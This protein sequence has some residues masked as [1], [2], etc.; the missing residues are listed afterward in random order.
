MEWEKRSMILL[1]NG[2]AQFSLK[3]SYRM[4][5][6]GCSR[7]MTYSHLRHEL[8]RS[9]PPTLQSNAAGKGLQK[10]FNDLKGLKATF[11]NSI[12]LG[13]DMA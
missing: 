4:K 2:Y 13:P 8:V 6:K 5:S 1:L 3:F 10:L 7:I 12:N 9:F 11:L